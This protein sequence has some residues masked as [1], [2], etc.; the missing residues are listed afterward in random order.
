MS[1]MQF[2]HRAGNG[3]IALSDAEPANGFHYVRASSISV[4]RPVWDKNDEWIGSD[5]FTLDGSKRRVNAS[6]EQIV[7]AINDLVVK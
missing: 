6:F 1:D 2:A 5:V 7:D 3:F 4:I